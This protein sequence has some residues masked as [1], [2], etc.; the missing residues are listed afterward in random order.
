MNI[1]SIIDA[2]KLHLF[3]FWLVSSYAAVL[4]SMCIDLIA[5]FIRCRRTHEIWLSDKQKRTADKAAKYFLPML[6]LSV[7]DFLALSVVSYPFFTLILA[8]I[9]SLTEWRSVFEK[10]NTKQEKQQAQQVLQLLIAHKDDVIQFLNELLN[11]SK[12]HENK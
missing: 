7:V 10:S 11:T 5:A 6:A 2:N 1:F 8:V 4:I 3:A 9:N 12:A